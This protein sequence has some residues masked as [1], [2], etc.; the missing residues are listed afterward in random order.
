MLASALLNQQLK[1][2]ILL[3][4]I[5][6]IEEVPLLIWIISRSQMCNVFLP[7]ILFVKTL[8]D[9]ILV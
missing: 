8:P 5:N 7:L 4:V 2:S 1:S 3:L 9:Y 6:L